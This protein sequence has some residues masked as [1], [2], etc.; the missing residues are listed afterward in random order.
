MCCTLLPHPTPTI[1]S[2]VC[3]P[4]RMPQKTRPLWWWHFAYNSRKKYYHQS[5]KTASDKAP[6]SKLVWYKLLVSLT[7]LIA[8]PLDTPGSPLSCLPIFLPRIWCF[9]LLILTSKGLDLGSV[10]PFLLVRTLSDRCLLP[11]FFFFPIFD[12]HQ[13]ILYM[14]VWNDKYYKVTNLA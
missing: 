9:C 12:G 6:S 5:S 13:L 3:Y 4:T 7:F 1:L 11:L 8:F 14:G 2:I 10:M